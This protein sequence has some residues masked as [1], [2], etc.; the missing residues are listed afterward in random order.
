MNA[1]ILALLMFGLSFGQTENS[2]TENETGTITVVIKNIEPNKGEL[3]AAV[4]PRD[5]FLKSSGHLEDRIL[6]V[7]DET[8]RT[9]VFENVPLGEEYAIAA[10]QD[11]DLSKKLSQ[12]A[13]G[14]PNEPYGFTG[15]LDSKW[16]KPNFEECAFVF[17]Q[18]E[19]TINIELKYWRQH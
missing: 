17:D 8:T 12:N 16:R 19:M 13:I 18:K 10:Y 7:K 15:K 14:V 9:I 4:Y 3:R 2:A 11:K 6:E 5:G 1:L